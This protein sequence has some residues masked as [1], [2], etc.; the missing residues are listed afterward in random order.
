ME[1]NFL[2]QLEEQTPKITNSGW[3]KNFKIIAP[4]AIIL[5]AGGIYA[6]KTLSGNGEVAGEKIDNLAKEVEILILDSNVQNADE[7]KT[8]GIVKAD[9]RVDAVAMANGTIRSINFQVGDYVNA[10]Q[11]L[12]YLHNSNALTNYGTAQA[13]YSNTQQSLSSIGRIT[14][15]S[16][17]QSQQGVTNAGIALKST[18]DN[19]NNAVELQ[20]TNK[21]DIINSSVIAYFGYLN[22]IQSALDQVDYII[23]ADGGQS[24]QLAGISDTLAARNVQSLSNAKDDYFDA[25]N[26]F[27]KLPQENISN[28]ALV[29]MKKAANSLSLTKQAVDATIIVLNNTISS[30][31]FSDSAF[32]AEKNPFIT[33]RNTVV[34]SQSALQTNLQSLQNIDLNQKRELDSLKNA[35]DAAKSQLEQ[36]NIALKNAREGKEQ[37]LISA[38]SALNASQGQLDLA[39]NQLADLSITAPISG[40]ITA[41]YAELGAEVSPGQKIAEISDMNLVKV[42]IDLTSEDVY[43]VELG[44]SAM[45]NGM[46]EGV[47]SRMNPSA[48]PV[49]KKVKIEIAFDNADKYLIPETFV[50]ITIPV[51]GRNG[52]SYSE[53]KFIIPLKAVT[54]TQTE[55][56]VFI[57]K[58][59]KAVKTSVEIGESE[60]DKIEIISGLQN[61]DELIIEG[62]RGLE[63]NEVVEIKN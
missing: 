54:I 29:N 32:K 44:Q 38:R 42:E 26:S 20:K 1:N 39:N 48:D 27:D 33:L 4:L 3:H 5:I 37:Q 49:S 57:A 9:S 21:E 45:I 31:N 17:R 46:F 35:V 51:D 24:G 14:D 12:A 41:K 22:T 59:N 36:A 63:G 23:G 30:H 19:Y 55:N 8:S 53:G 58:D 40:Q 15:E 34:N 16:I 61:G 2:E 47:I 25:K 10:G 28:N 43:R 13:N 6:A 7:I 52:A 18:Q 60:G 50:D 11:P 56:Y 62:N